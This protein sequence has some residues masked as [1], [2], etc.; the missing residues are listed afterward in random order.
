[1]EDLVGKNL[2]EYEIIAHIGHGAV[3]DVYKAFQPM[4]DRHVAIKVLSPV[5]ANEPGFRERFRREAHAIAQ[6]DHPNILPVYDFQQGDLTYIVMQY[7]D[8]GSLDDLVGQPLPIGFVL[9]VLEQVGSALSYA[10]SQSIVHR[11]VKPGNILL[12][13][14]NWVLLT[15]FG[16]VKTL[17][18]PSKL[19]P[20]GMSLGTPAY[21][22]PEQVTGDPADARADVY[23]LGATLYQMLTGRVPFEGESG[24]AVALKHVSEALIPPRALNPNL[25]PSVNRVIAKALAK[26]R[27]LRYQSVDEL[28]IAFREA[29]GRV[30]VGQKMDATR[31]IGEALRQSTTPVDTPVRAAPPSAPA[32]IPLEAIWPPLLERST[33]REGSGWALLAALAGTLVGLGLVLWGLAALLE[34]LL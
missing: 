27:D 28:V 24:M 26:A 11:D 21:M 1:M 17:Q 22:A 2:G 14:E 32:P 6:L 33:G 30:T 25:S 20:S 19:T 16:L 8:T 7:V 3:A 4:L 12:G 29:V 9:E 31:L 13:P 5:F 10:H 23:A 18:I 15:D 34:A